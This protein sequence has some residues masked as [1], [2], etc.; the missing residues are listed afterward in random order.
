MTARV[1][2]VA[3]IALRLR[4]ADPAPT[5]LNTMAFAASSNRVVTTELL[6]TF[7]CTL[8]LTYIRC[9]LHRRGG[10]RPPVRWNHRS[11]SIRP[12]NPLYRGWYAN[13]KRCSIGV[14]CHSAAV[15]VTMSTSS[16]IGFPVRCRSAHNTHHEWKWAISLYL[17][18]VLT[19][20]IP[21]P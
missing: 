20:I 8:V 16:S 3:L 9:G 12:I 2:T 19:R 11:K 7:D 1:R 13:V 6:F 18:S 21:E 5:T 15:L 10:T 4:V 17:M 14:T